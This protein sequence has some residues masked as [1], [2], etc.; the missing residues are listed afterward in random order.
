MTKYL[1]RIHNRMPVI[2]NPTH[3][4]AWLCPDTVEPAA[5]IIEPFAPI[6]AYRV[7][8]LVNKPENDEPECMEPID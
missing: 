6:S 3:Y 4:D 8:T 5:L 1:E 2:L 7:S